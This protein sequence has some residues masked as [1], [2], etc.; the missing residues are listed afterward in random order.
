MHPN[1]NRRH[2][3]KHSAAAALAARAA[4][5]QAA[6]PVRTAFIGAGNRGFHLLRNVVKLDGVSIVA[7]CDTKPDRLDKALSAAGRD[8]PAGFADYRKLL[9]RKDLDAVFIATPCDL[10][11]EMA[12]AAL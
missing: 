9:E 2:F 4:A 11:V 3:L 1:W 12:I 5:Q 7:V 8:N 6:P 10:H